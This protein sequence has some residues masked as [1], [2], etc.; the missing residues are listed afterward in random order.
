MGSAN[1][2]TVTPPPPD[3]SVVIPFYNEGPNVEPLLSELRQCLDALA[4][5]HEVIAID[6]GSSDN[7]A[8]VLTQ[9]SSAWPLLHT[10][11][12]PRN[13]GQAAALWTGFTAARGAWIATLDG[14][15]QNPPAELAHLWAERMTADL[16]NGRRRR[17]EDSQ[18][19]RTMSRIAN[20]FRR[21][22]LDDGVDDSGCALRLFRREVLASLLPL[23]TLYSFIPAMA[24]THGWTVRQLD[25][26]H[27]PRV[28]GVS[29]YG[30]LVMA[31]RPLLDTL[32][33]A[34]LLRRRL[35]RVEPPSRPSAG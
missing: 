15:G 27:R 33:L 8:A 34:W 17:R 16:L 28:A 18:L 24:S 10:I 23:R 35:P 13:R 7:T 31:W 2:P 32:A 22:L 11:T 1:C 21:L 20:G 25:V 19:R 3:L 4:V 29:K 12:L 9:I 26:A 14:D 5:N 30:L 6:D